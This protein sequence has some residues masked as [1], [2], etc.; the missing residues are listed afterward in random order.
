MREKTFF[1]DVYKVAAFDLD[2]TLLH[3]GKM[4]EI[5]RGSVFSLREKGLETVISTGRPFAGIPS[6]VLD[7][8]IFRY[9]ITTNGAY[10]RDTKENKCIY[11]R[12]ISADIAEGIVRQISNV[13]EYGHVFIEHEGLP[14]KNEHDVFPM[15]FGDARPGC[16]DWNK[17]TYPLDC[18]HT[19]KRLVHKIECKMSSAKAG[20][21]FVQAIR[22]SFDVEVELTAE[23]NIE[24]TAKGVNKGSAL[25]WLCEY[26]GYSV[27][28]V[29]AFGDGNNDKAI[30]D[31]AG[32]SVVMGDAPDELKN[33]GCYLAETSANDGVALAII[34]LFM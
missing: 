10:I 23:S 16:V 31:I 4:S 18:I 6:E 9:V 34:E 24:I 19:N 30:L 12:T 20:R 26:T 7:M 22:A 33:S 1:R 21:D 25:K 29:I 8:G 28:E 3:Q 32:Y 5:V 13:A 14:E 11:S 15:Q 2:G 17:I 27:E